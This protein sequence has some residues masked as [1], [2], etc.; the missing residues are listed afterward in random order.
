MKN[1][2]EFI[3][4]RSDRTRPSG[5][6]QRIDGYFVYDIDAQTVAQV[7]YTFNITPQSVIDKIEE[8]S[9]PNATN[10]ASKE[11]R[12]RYHRVPRQDVLN[13]I[14]ARKEGCF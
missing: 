5:K 6:G 13:Y 7:A 8:G 1:Q 3:D 11:A 2:M 14:Q 10:L 9:F 4:I 12:K